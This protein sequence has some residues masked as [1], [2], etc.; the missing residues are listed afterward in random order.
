MPADF[1]PLS[2]NLQTLPLATKFQSLAQ[3]LYPTDP[4][5]LFYQSM[6]M[7][8]FFFLWGDQRTPPP[9]YMAIC[10][11]PL[12][13][14]CLCFSTIFLSEQAWTEN[15]FSHSKFFF[16]NSLFGQNPEALSDYLASIPPTL[17]IYTP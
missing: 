15:S 3:R 13:C 8:F 11:F 14:Y 4:F 5:F 17:S 9:K 2:N 16:V 6:P 10:C 7:G 1:F 12:P